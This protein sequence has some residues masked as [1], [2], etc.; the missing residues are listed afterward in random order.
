LQKSLCGNL[1]GAEI[2]RPDI[3]RPDNARPH[4]KGGHHETELRGC[5]IKQWCRSISWFL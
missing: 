5:Q 4:S 3:A 1:G 2:A